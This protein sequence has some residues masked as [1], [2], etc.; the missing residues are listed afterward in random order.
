MESMKDESGS[1]NIKTPQR[2][3]NNTWITIILVVIVVAG[4]FLVYSYD[5]DNKKHGYKKE[6]GLVTLE[7]KV[8]YPSWLAESAT[9]SEITKIIDEQREMVQQ[10]VNQANN[11]QPDLYK[12]RGIDHFEFIV[13]DFMRWRPN[14]WDSIRFTTQSFTGGAHYNTYLFSVNATANGEI[15][16]NIGDY[17]RTVSYDQETFL[18]DLNK[19]LSTQGRTAVE[20]IGDVIVWNLRDVSE[21]GQSPDLLISFPPC[22]VASCADGIIEVILPVKG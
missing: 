4:I 7:G 16:K 1:E 3:C 9:E 17:L 20:T 11:E 12:K 6:T 13:A 2:K 18:T 21:E 8:D 19:A 5:S 15:V 22:N 14:S 10:A